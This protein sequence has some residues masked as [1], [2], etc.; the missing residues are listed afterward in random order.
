MLR[1]P[2][3]V[4]QGITSPHSFN[5]H[6]NTKTQTHLFYAVFFST[7]VFDYFSSLCD[8]LCEKGLANLATVCLALILETFM[9]SRGHLTT[10]SPP[11]PSLSLLLPRPSANRA[12]SSAEYRDELMGGQRKGKTDRWM[13]GEM[14][15]CM[16]EWMD[17]W[18]DKGHVF[19]PVEK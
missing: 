17:A 18:M 11:L 19:K 4:S 14:D 13:D 7:V 6:F 8:S 12:V 10:H 1:I 3:P 9:L 16:H 15:G 5:S 2:S